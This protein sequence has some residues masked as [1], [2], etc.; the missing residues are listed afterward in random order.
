MQRAL[1]IVAYVL[2]LLAL[3]ALG[4]LLGVC[5][6]AAETWN[7]SVRNGLAAGQSWC[8]DPEE[9]CHAM[10]LERTQAICAEWEPWLSAY[11]GGV[12]AIVVA[13]TIRT[14][15]EGD[16]FAHTGSWTRECGLTSVDLLHAEQF[17]VNACDPEAA[18]WQS[19]V[20]RNLQLLNLLAKFP[21]L[22]LAPLADQ[23]ALA[24]ACGAVG[25]HRVVRMIVRS[26]ALDTNRHAP[27]LRYA[28]PYRRVVEWLARQDATDALLFGPRA[29]ITAF[30]VARVGAAHA[31][32]GSLFA[33]GLP[34]GLPSLADRPE[35]IAPYPG[36]AAH[37]KCERW[38]WL[39]D[40]RP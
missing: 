15:S 27:G 13:G 6:A 20:G 8:A 24:G 10:H 29:G 36:P 1:E 21:Q 3:V 33:D 31:L 34:W 30:R 17:D 32:L 12:P 26:G 14:E 5:V 39:E 37:G 38:P 35:G 4:M 28:S 9:P 23:W 2:V 25:S 19:G 40:K 16:P 7:P 11:G 22:R 18:I